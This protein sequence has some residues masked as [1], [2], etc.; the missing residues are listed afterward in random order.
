MEAP[1][2]IT[3][4][5]APRRPRATPAGTRH[6]HPSPHP[7]V[8][9]ASGALAHPGSARR[10]GP[11]GAGGRRG[12]VLP[13][14]PRADGGRRSM[15]PGGAATPGGHAGTLPARA[16]TAGAAPCTP[17]SRPSTRSC[18]LSSGLFPSPHM[19]CPPLPLRIF[20]VDLGS[21]HSMR[22]CRLATSMRMDRAARFGGRPSWPWGAGSGP[23][24][25]PGRVPVWRPF[26]S[27]KEPYRRV[28]CATRQR[29]W[30][31]TRDTAITKHDTKQ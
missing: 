31:K 22:R 9:A 7:T 29:T 20:V 5:G 4:H 1:Q 18:A 17:G 16:W 6:R 27:T 30:R 19:P 2:T 11:R 28:N 15:H 23:T 25:E 8:Q 26:P 10:Y 24:R 3:W 21:H 13:A 14:G 12:P